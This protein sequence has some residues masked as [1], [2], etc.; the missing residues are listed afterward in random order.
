MAANMRP[1]GQ[2]QMLVSEDQRGVMVEHDFD[3]A[4]AD[5]LTARGHIVTRAAPD[6]T[7]F[8]AAQLIQ[9]VDGGYVGASEKRRDGQAVGF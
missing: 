6:S 7:E 4:V 1:Q 9:K 3:P 2:V 5:A 8:G